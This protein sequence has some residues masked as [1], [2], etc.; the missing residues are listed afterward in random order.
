MENA[1]TVLN[2]FK[3]IFK[4]EIG[5]DLEIQEDKIVVSLADG[6]KAIVKTKNM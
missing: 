5:N 2:F 4:K 1:I 3:S 6:T